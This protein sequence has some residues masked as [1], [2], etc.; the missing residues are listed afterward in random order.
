MSSC[1][2]NQWGIASGNDPLSDD[3]SILQPKVYD[4]ECSNILFLS[5]ITFCSRLLLRVCWLCSLLFMKLQPHG[6]AALSRVAEYFGLIIISCADCIIYKQ[7]DVGCLP[8]QG[9]CISNYD[10]YD[11]SEPGLA[12]SGRCGGF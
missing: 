9:F 2:M 12:T 8:Q 11:R 6:F 7:F 4:L 5:R 3:S 1:N 10:R